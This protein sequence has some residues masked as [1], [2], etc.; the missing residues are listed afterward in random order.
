[1]F[2]LQFVNI[3]CTNN[4]INVHGSHVNEWHWLDLN[5]PWLVE[6]PEYL[7]E[8]MSDKNTAVSKLC[9]KTLDIIAVSSHN[10]I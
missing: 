9:I 2:T 3:F 5:L 10:Y 8:L 7:L 1:M 4:A 6:A